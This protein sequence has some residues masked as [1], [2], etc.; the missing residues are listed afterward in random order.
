MDQ[1]SVIQLQ[2][3]EL[4]LALRTD[5][6]GAVAG[7]WLDDLP[8]LR[9]CD[10]PALRSARESGCYALV[11]Y[12]NRIARREFQWL[13]RR[14]ALAANSD[15]PHTIHG[16][17][18]L[19]RWQVQ[20]RADDRVTLAYTHPSDAQWPFAFH[21]E[22]TYELKPDALRITLAA[23]NIDARRTPMGLGWHPFFV[24]RARSRLHLE[25]THRWDASPDKLP[26]RRVAQSGL[27]TDVAGLDLDNCFEGWR[28]P[29]RIRDE[30]LSLRMTSS[31][32]HVVIYTPRDLDRFCVEPVSHVNNA[33]GS[34]D[35][36]A[37]GM[38]SL[39]SGETAEAWMLLEVA[40]P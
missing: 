36:L 38:R 13:G 22:Q 10:P 18:W 32:D 23:S 6:G 15:E 8:V 37:L 31:L 34:D 19:H 11:P 26:L 16:V 33:L 14:Y 29:A 20:Q 1:D 27:D 17:G 4:R 12:S 30:R 21:V 3:G 2:Q 5:C 28:G 35:P 39:A 7:L 40:R 25:L 9:S 24:R